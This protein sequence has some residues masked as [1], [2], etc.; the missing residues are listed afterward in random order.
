VTSALVLSGS[1]YSVVATYNG[2]G[3]F[4]TSASAAKPIRVP[5]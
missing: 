4:E 1:P 5:R 2:D 3:T